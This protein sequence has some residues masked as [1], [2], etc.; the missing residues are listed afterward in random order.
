MDCLATCLA[1]AE[2]PAD[3][4]PLPARA[5]PASESEAMVVVIPAERITRPT[6]GYPNSEPFLFLAPT[7]LAVGLA[8]KELALRR[9]SCDSPP[10]PAGPQ[11]VPR[12]PAAGRRGNSAWVYC[13]RGTVPNPRDGCRAPDTLKT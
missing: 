3:A 9:K 5:V 12:S 4:P 6:T 8:L 1:G 13:S 10:G 7:G 2:P 11:W